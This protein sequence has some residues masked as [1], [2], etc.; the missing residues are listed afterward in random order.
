L[1]FT[2]PVA[3]DL[4]SGGDDD[5][6]GSRGKKSGDDDDDNDNGG[7]DD[8]GGIDDCERRAYRCNYRKFYPGPPREVSLNAS[9]D[10]SLLWIHSMNTLDLGM[11]Q[12]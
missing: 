9:L 12:T 2:T 4:L 10:C 1:K 5:D 11:Y 6:G 8:G 7:D 3:A